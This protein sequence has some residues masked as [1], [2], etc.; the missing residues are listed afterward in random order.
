MSEHDLQARPI[1]RHERDSIEAH[2]T[3]PECGAPPA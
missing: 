2:L 3:I 1:Y